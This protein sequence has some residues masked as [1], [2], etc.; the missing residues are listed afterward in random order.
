MK[1]FINPERSLYTDNLTRED[2]VSTLSA[3]ERDVADFFA[4][5]TPEEVGF[6][7]DS[8]WTAAEQL[9]H[10]N[11]AV[12]AVAKGFAVPR[13]ILHIRYGRSR[14]SGRSY[15]ALRDDYRARLAAG[16]RASGPFVPNRDDLSAAQGEVRRHELLARW[17][18]I[19]G[20][21]RKTLESWDEEDLDTI[22]LPHPLLGKITAREMIYFTVYHSEHHVAATK[23]RLPRLAGPSAG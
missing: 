10:L 13:I 23:K 3:S 7:V 14:S 20:R 16:G 11:S 15:S 8:A 12:S 6:R 1:N 18:R 2:L 17:R 9:A 22:R 4:S 19:N 5:L 21:L